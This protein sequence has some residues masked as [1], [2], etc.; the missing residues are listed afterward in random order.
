[1]IYQRPVCAALFDEADFLEPIG[2]PPDFPDM[3][4]WRRRIA[5]RASRPPPH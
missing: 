3:R 1:V 4:V 2:S 5:P